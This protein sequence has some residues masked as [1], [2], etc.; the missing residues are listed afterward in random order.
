MKI[1]FLK[2]LKTHLVTYNQTHYNIRPADT[3]IIL[4]YVGGC[5]TFII[6]FKNFF[7][8]VMKSSPVDYNTKVWARI[9]GYF[10]IEREPFVFKPEAA[11]FRDLEKYNKLMD[12]KTPEKL[13]DNSKG[14]E[15]FFYMYLPRYTREIVI[16]FNLVE[17]KYIVSRIAT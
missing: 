1:N 12:E 5:C 14:S 16:C 6:W 3:I 8:D 10:R 4:G 11:E 2:K 17:S 9:K 7:M 15:D 13:Y